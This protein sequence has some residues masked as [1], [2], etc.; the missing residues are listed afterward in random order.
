MSAQTLDKQRCLLHG[1]GQ[2]VRRDVFGQ[3][4]ARYVQRDHDV[5][6]LLLD[7]NML[8]ADARPG[9]RYRQEEYS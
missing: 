8:L 9:Q 3:H 5:R 1:A 6:A 4:T 2:A 7:H